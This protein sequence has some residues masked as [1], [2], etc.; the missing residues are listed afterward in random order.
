MEDNLERENNDIEIEIEKET[1]P[2][3]KKLTIFNFLLIILIFVGLFTYM[4]KVDGIDNILKI[5]HTAV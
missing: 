5:L 3:N 4:I 2:V 1:K